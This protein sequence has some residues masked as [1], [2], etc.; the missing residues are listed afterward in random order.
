VGGPSLHDPRQLDALWQ[1]IRDELRQ[2]APEFTFHTWLAPLEL[3]GV[4]GRTLHVRAPEHIRSW[5]AERYLGLLRRA[6]MR[7]FDPRAEV[8]IVAVDWRPAERV[9]E[10]VPE[11]NPR[12]TFEQFVIGAGN[13][14]AHAA[15]LAVAEMPS[16]TYNPLFIHGPPGLGKTHLLHAIGNYVRRYGA[17]LRVR[18]ATVEAFTGEFVAAL[19]SQRTASFKDSFRTPDVVLIDDVQFLARRERTREEF[20]HTFN[21][22]LESGRQLVLTSDRPPEEVVEVEERLTQRFRAGLVAELERPGLDVRRAILCKRACLDDV[23]VDPEVIDEIARLVTGSVR[24]LE[25]AMIRVAAYAS[26]RGQPITPGLARHVLRRLE[27]AAPAPRCSIPEIVDATAREFGLP[28]EELIAHG[29]RPAAAQA[30]SKTARI[31]VPSGRQTRGYPHS[32]AR[33]VRPA[34]A[35]G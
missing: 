26:V 27:P 35:S 13:R 17:P 31:P 14:L 9:P 2:E 28:P 23:A 19:R 4:D 33:V 12:Y 3:A 25:G 30:P 20:F 32:R 34:A 16:Q 8:E 29:R 15:A 5:V 11:L 22:L 18:Y 24:V 7:R 1:A 21:A 10:R 6:A